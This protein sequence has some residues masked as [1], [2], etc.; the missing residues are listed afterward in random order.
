MC[1]KGYAAQIRRGSEG[2]AALLPFHSLFP[3][4]RDGI[5]YDRACLDTSVP[6]WLMQTLSTETRLLGKLHLHKYKLLLYG[7]RIHFY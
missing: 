1:K 6:L 2:K 5:L 3:K 4:M 7:K